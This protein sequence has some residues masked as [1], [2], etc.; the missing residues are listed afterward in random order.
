MKVEE[1]LRQARR[2]LEGAGVDNP[3]LDAGVL[4]SHALKTEP[5]R[6]TVDNRRVLTPGERRRILT[7]VK[8]RLQGEPVAYITGKKEFYALEFMV[9]PDVLIPRPETELLVDMVLYH[10]GPGASVLDVGTGSGAIAVSV[11]HNRPDLKVCATDISPA[12]LRVARKNCRRLLGPGAVEFLEG[13]L[14]SPVGDRRFN[15]IV[16]NPPYI[17]PDEKDRLQR[18]IRS[19]PDIALYA[20]D[21]GTGVISL[22]VAGA[23]AHIEGS[24]MLVIEIGHDQKALILESGAKHGFSVSVLSDYAGFPRVALLKSEAGRTNSLL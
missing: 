18:E 2:E 14:F 24:G 17:N 16:S 11:R 8:R 5:Y 15:I 3:G 22:L 13:D 10:A 19:E 23:A 20:G 9:T 4:I 21:R 12:A 7:M 1:A 6:L